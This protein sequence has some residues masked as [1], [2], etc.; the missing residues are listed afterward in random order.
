[1]GDKVHEDPAVSLGY[2]LMVADEPLLWDTLYLALYCP[3]DRAPRLQEHCM[4]IRGQPL[5][6]TLGRDM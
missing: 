5:C 1:M 4:E 6:P 2:R 3:A